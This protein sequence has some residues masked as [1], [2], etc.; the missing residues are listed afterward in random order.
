[1]HLGLLSETTGQTSLSPTAKVSVMPT[2]LTYAQALWQRAERTPR[3]ELLRTAGCEPWTAS[4]VRG[5]AASWAIGLQPVATGA[6]VVTCVD[7][8]PEAVALTCAISA[9]GATELPLGADASVEWAYRLVELTR[10]R[11]IVTS[12]ERAD[13][14]LVQQLARLPGRRLELVD[15]ESALDPD[16]VD[17]DRLTPIDLPSTAAATMVA[18]SGTTGRQK[19]ALL[20]VGAPIRQARQVAATM[21]YG[22]DDVLLSLFH[23]HHINARHAIVLPAVL[24]GAR[25]VFAPHFSASGFWDLVRREGVTGFSFMGA[26]GMMLLR[27]PPSPTDRDHSLTKAYGGPAPAELVSA[28][29]DRFAVTLRQAYACTELGDVST[30]SMGQLRSGAAGRPLDDR[31]LR[32]VDEQLHDV[33][34][35]TTGEILVR[36]RNTDTVFLEYVGDS[37]QTTAAWESGWFRTRDRGHL[38]DGWLHVTGRTSDVIRRRGINLDPQQIEDALLTHPAVAEAAAV[39]VPSELTEDELLAIV[40]P[41]T[42]TRLT[43]ETL[44][45]HCEQVLPR[46]SRPRYLSVEDSLPHSANHK[47]DRAQLRR[48]GVPANAWDTEVHLATPETR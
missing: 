13:S 31:E 12:A 29:A 18:T 38:V 11:V 48:R 46:S 35:G 27:Q 41:S 23:W 21:Q 25:V 33:P 10:A 40:V 28:F 39:A 19:A 16:L 34:D 32:I 45:Q 37:E 14:P 47:L 8:S 5:C 3:G 22:D 43:P 4:R 30:T 2:T 7:S 42:A 20:P 24:S 36:P 1:M 15:G 44:W 26:V 6:V 9:L 17:A